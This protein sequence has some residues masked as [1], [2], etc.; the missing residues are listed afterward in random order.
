M[1]EYPNRQNRF[2]NKLHKSLPMYPAQ[3]AVGSTVRKKERARERETRATRHLKGSRTVLDSGFHSV[4]SGFHT[5]DPKSCQQNLDSS[6]HR[7]WDSGFQEL[8]SVFQSLGFGIAQAKIQRI[9]DSTRKNSRIPESGFSYM[10][11]QIGARSR[12]RAPMRASFSRLAT[13][14]PRRACSQVRVSS[15]D[16]HWENKY[17]LKRPSQERLAPRSLS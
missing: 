5:L 16:M 6:F 1:K 17:K 2:K 10:G 7:K 15:R 11:R 4:D 12:L 3:Q 9:P 8:Q 14:A 13:R